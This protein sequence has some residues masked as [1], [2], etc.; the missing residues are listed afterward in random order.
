MLSTLIG[1]ARP[2]APPNRRLSFTASVLATLGLVTVPAAHAADE[3]K[4]GE[5]EEI[6]VTARNVEESLQEA[7]VAVTAIGE[8][9]LDIFRIDEAT[10]LVSRI[11]ALNVSVGGSG[12][13]AQISLR[14]IG[15]SF[16]S[17]SFDSAVALNFDDVSIS[18]QRLLQ[19]AFFDVEQVAVLKGPQ[20]LYF[21]KAASAGVLSLRSANPTEEWE[22]FVKS[23]YEFEEEGATV[24]G[25]ASGPLSDTL[26]FRLAAEYQDIDKRVRIADGN[27]TVD[28][29]RGL[30]NFIA[31]LTL[32]WA[33]TDRFNANLKINYNEQN[34]QILNSDL[35]IF[36]GGDGIPDPSILVGGAITGGGI[37]G[38]DLF[39][40]THDCDINDGRFTGIDT[41]PAIN[42]VP[43]GSPGENRDVS[44]AYNDT[45][46]FFTR[47]QLDF[48]VSE[49][50]DLSLFVGYLDLE[51]EYN[52]TFN[53]TGQLPD[54]TAAGL[55]APFEN[56]LEQ[57]T[58]EARFASNLSGPVNFQL[59]A[60]FENR[61][62]GHRTSQN[63]FNPTLF[64]PL[65][66]PFGADAVT[67]ATFDWLA[68]RPI[69]AEALSFFGSVDIQLSERWELTGGLRWTDEEKSTSVAFP[70]VHSGVVALFGTVESGFQSDDVEFEDDNL[71]PEVVLRYL[72]NDNVSLYAAY[73]NGFKS[74]GID[75]NTLPT[76]AVIGLTSPD[77]DVVA[78]TEE[79]LIFE[80]EESEGFEVGVRS[81]LADRTVTLNVTAYRY[82]FDNQQVQ[83]FDPAVFA[84]STFNAGE[85]TTQ[86]I[87]VDFIW[88]TPVPGLSLSGAWA[89]LDAEITG[90]FFAAG[91]NLRGR[92][93]GF[94]PEVSG[95]LAVNWETA[96][97]D[98][99]YL[100]ISPNLAYK[101]DFFVGT[102]LEFD[103]VTNPTGALIQDSYVTL[104]LNVSLSAPNDRWRLSFIGRNL[105]D[106]QFLTFAGPAPFRPPGTDDQLV[107]IGRGAQ[108][109]VEAAVRF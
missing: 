99:L 50:Y 71:S 81:Q 96:L 9:T 10:D 82:E 27:P 100:R 66:P 14:G 108:F 68:D 42:Q 59:G 24:G 98:S 41:H 53:S 102:G 25:Y 107:G 61:D 83:I 38:V 29:N 26:G 67:G 65:G 84:F 11:P 13:S 105:T 2:S 78:A 45:D 28:P 86:G 69:D 109:F 39:A 5:I 90:D 8:E 19:T 32:D 58:V 85:V 15:S 4:I 87:D 52:D 20:S 34:S 104:D 74:G 37:P 7:P 94:A 23:S 64:A 22:F 54:G 1:G 77:P 17:N 106:E 89:F 72:V 93:A 49:S 76:G 88:Q 95:N 30:E 33:P 51:N 103:A 44:V 62:I 31:R 46:I 47:L 57:T 35:D 6:V 92:D 73:K 75:N 16:I 21:G 56:T 18:T 40:P 70:F 91:V 101:D 97:T 43:E 36:C 12:A 79:L 3:R 63:A 60:F 80:S 48:A 55:A